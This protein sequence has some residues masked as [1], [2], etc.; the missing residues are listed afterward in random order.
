MRNISIL[1]NLGLQYYDVYKQTTCYV[2][3][4]SS[5]A[6]NITKYQTVDIWSSA[7]K[8]LLRIVNIQTEC[9]TFKITSRGYA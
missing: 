4:M 9:S 7:N 8:K 6:C 5:Y 2:Y 1:Y 3:G